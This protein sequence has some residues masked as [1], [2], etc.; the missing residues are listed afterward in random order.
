[1][2]STLEARP[3]L[4]K[5]KALGSRPVGDHTRPAVNPS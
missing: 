4:V 3:F 1:M 5:S 2:D